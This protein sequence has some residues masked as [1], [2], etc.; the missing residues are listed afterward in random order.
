[1][2]PSL[3]TLSPSHVTAR[4]EILARAHLKPA[5]HWALETNVVLYF[6]PGSLTLGLGVGWALPWP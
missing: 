6:V 5:Q 3:G 4:M 2:F 1:M